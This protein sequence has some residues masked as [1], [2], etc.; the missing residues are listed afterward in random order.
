MNV[1]YDTRKRKSNGVVV[2]G[3]LGGQPRAK[4]ENKGDMRQLYVAERVYRFYLNENEEVLKAE[5]RHYQSATYAVSTLTYEGEVAEVLYQMAL[6]LAETL[7]ETH[8]L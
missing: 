1:Y 4:I 8:R 2:V 5:V 6:D 3:D 7:P